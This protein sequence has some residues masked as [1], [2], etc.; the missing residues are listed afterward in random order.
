MRD[1][2]NIEW[3]LGAFIGSSIA[4]VLFA[5]QVYLVGKHLFALKLLGVLF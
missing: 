3:D 4:T 5:S 2:K 1:I